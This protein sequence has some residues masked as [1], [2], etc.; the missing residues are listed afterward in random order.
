MSVKQISVFVENKPGALAKLTR[1]M[2]DNEIN[3]RALSIADT[4]DFGILRII[5]A[6]PDRADG[7]LREAGYLTKLNN[8]L[9]VAMP[10]R[11]GAL[12]DVLGVL[13]GANVGV[14]YT[15]AFVSYKPG[16]AYMIFR[17]DDRAA[18]E[19]ALTS[20]GIRLVEQSEI[21]A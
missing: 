8:V 4:Q 9:A 7:I 16:E 20:A 11:P 5:T 13:S 17:V 2:A 15:Y 12:A 18:A 3:L 19:Q 1:F 10:D 21:F 14:E 6:R